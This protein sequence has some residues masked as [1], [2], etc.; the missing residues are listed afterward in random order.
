MAAI[1]PSRRSRCGLLDSRPAPMEI[2]SW[3]PPNI[4]GL[5]SQGGVEVPTGG[6]CAKIARARE[7]LPGKTGRVSRLGAIPRPTVT[8]RMKE[9]GQAS[10]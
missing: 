10:R 8:V 2:S 4:G 1:R 6:N 9:N 7:R 5:R 3:P